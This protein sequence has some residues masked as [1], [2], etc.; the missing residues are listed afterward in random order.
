MDIQYVVHIYY[1]NYNILSQYEQNRNFGRQGYRPEFH[2]SAEYF[3]NGSA[4]SM[5][6]Y[7]LLP[8]P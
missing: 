3:A 1:I 7:G 5:I 8:S 6:Q 4:Y 2:Q